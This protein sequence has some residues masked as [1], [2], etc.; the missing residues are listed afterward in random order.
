MNSSYYCLH[1]DRAWCQRHTIWHSH[2]K[3]V[4]IILSIFTWRHG[5]HVG[6]QKDSEMVFWECQSIIMQN[7]SDVLPLFFTPNWSS[8][9]V[10]EKQELDSWRKQ[11]VERRTHD[12]EKTERKN[13]REREEREMRNMNRKKSLRYWEQQQLCPPSSEPQAKVFVHKHFKMILSTWTFNS[14][15]NYKT[16]RF[17]PSYDLLRRGKIC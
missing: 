9:H 15:D 3:N 10:S 4:G 12:K 13:E 11:Y 6:V 16:W 7:L 8:H 14:S 2:R 17:L 1:S 5:D